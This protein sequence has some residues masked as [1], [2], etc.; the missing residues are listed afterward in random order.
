[1]PNRRVLIVC[2]TGVQSIDVTGPLEAFYDAGYQVRLGT[3]GGTPVRSSSG[4]LLTPDIALERAWELDIL[5]VPGGLGSRLPEPELITWL[6]TRG[7]RARQLVSVC[8]GTFSLAAAGLLAGR[9]VTTHWAQCTELARRHPE[10]EVLAEPIFVRDGHVATSAGATAGIDLALALIEEELGWDTALTV[11]R[12]MVMFLRR[13][14]G[15]AQF[16]V[17]LATQ[18][19]DRAP[20]RE[21]QQWIS[22]HPE[23][24]LSI[25]A[26]AQRATLSPRQF[27]RAFTTEVG[28]SPGRYVDQVRLE[29]ARRRLEDTADGI[30]EIARHCGYRTTEAMRRAFHRVLGVSA[31]DYRRRFQPAFEGNNHD[32]ST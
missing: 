13:P 9:R 4:L 23:A 21:V 2:F 26:L 28:M 3:M 1:M 15:Q 10:L 24:D 12:N 16:S 30:E 19:A 8:T 29:A 7:P 22:E 6:R 17:Q 18:L 31:A 25:P 32:V 14:G 27:T 11:A 20:V 5:L